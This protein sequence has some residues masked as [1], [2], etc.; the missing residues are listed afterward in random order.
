[1]LAVGDQISAVID[2]GP[3][4]IGGIAGLDPAAAVAYL[5]PE[6]TPTAI[7][8]DR[9]AASEWADERGLTDLVPAAERWAAAY[10]TG[11]PDDERLQSWCRRILLSDHHRSSD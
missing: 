4:T 9:D 5:A 11:A 3:T 2:F 6:I 10:W 7:E 8:A 1:M